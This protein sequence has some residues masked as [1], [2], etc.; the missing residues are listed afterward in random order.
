MVL[1]TARER[2]CLITSS[3]SDLHSTYSSALCVH[4]KGR[5]LQKKRKEEKEKKKLTDR[6]CQHRQQQKVTSCMR[7]L[8][9][10]TKELHR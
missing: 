7:T 5:V 9:A 4:Y 10:T 6:P 3:A 8:I 1:N 2:H